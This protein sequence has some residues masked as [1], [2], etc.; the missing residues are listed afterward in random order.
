MA[1][2]ESPLSRQRERRSGSEMAE[3]GWR[4]EAEAGPEE[5]EDDGLL[6]VTSPH[7]DPFLA[8]Y[9]HHQPALP[10]PNVRT[11]NNMAEYQSFLSGRS[12]HRNTA[13]PSRKARGRRTASARPPPDP[14]RIE[15]LK[16]L[17][18]AEPSGDERPRPRRRDRAPKNVLTRMALHEGSPLG[19]LYRCV[20]DR[21]RI[22]VHIRTFKGLRGV[23]TG[24]LVT[25]DKF[26]NMVMNAALVDVDETF[27]KPILGKAFHNE[28]ALTVSRLFDRLKLQ[29]RSTDEESGATTMEQTGCLSKRFE[30]AKGRLGDSKDLSCVFKTESTE[31]TSETLKPSAQSETVDPDQSKRTAE[32][33]SLE[34]R[35]P[36][37]EKPKR[38]KKARPRVDYQQVSQ[39]HVK[40]LFIRGENILLISLMQ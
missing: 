36:M 17:M 32:Q 10:F 5:E 28:A 21:I 35:T 12:G 20:Q 40:Q 1:A 18:V 13:A 33:T 25:F 34:L 7:F 30:G 27:R 4:E 38:K 16:K 19:E 6:D 8:L 37:E 11:F 22:N 29:E 31:V 3:S 9:S 39:R 26:W 14:E 23:C 15:R 24:F 2:C